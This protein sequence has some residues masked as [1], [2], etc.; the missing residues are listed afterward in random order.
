MGQFDNFSPHPRMDD[1]LKNINFKNLN[2]LSEY[3]IKEAINSA[4]EFFGIPF[5]VFVQDLSSFKYGRTLFMNIDPT[6]YEDDILYYNMK[7]LAE[8]NVGSKEA[9]SI[10]MTHECAHRV[11]QSVR[12]EGP[13]DGAWQGELAA[14]FLM[15][16]R[17][18]FCNMEHINHVIEGLGKTV[19]TKTHPKGYLRANFINYGVQLAYHVKSNSIPF[20]INELITEYHNHYIEM[21]AYVKRDEK[22]IYTLLER[23]NR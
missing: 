8:L 23:L 14:D 17:A 9:F 21:Q 16:F 5:P 3:D 1:F 11:L 12:F 7:E 22:E 6:T 18:G 20:S 4:C 10:I 13:Y 15:G 19:G 2:G